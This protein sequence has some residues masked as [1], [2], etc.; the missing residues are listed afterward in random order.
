MRA[1]PSSDELA[2]EAESFSKEGK[3]VYT[4]DTESAEQREKTDPSLRSG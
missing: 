1:C 2:L 3:G 4:E